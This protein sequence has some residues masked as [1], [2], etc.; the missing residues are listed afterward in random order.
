VQELLESLGLMAIPLAEILGGRDVLAPDTHS[1][2]VLAYS[3][4]PDS[5]DQH[6]L[7]VVGADLVVHSR[8]PN[9]V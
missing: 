5:I 3:P 1:G 4:R 9:P 2:V 8:H 7:A 6:A